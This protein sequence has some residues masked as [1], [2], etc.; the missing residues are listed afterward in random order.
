MIEKIKIKAEGFNT[1]IKIEVEEDINI[2][3]LLKVFKA[4]TL[5]LGYS[6]NT[7]H[8]GILEYV[9]DFNLFEK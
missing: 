8:G 7:F 1:K 9:E 4:I 2:T 6:E 5:S 3:D